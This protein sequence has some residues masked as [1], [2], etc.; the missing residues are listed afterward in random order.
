MA[1]F[2][3]R[4]C[5]GLI[6]GMW[7]LMWGV[8]LTKYLQARPLCCPCRDATIQPLLSPRGRN[9]SHHMS[10]TSTLT[11]LCLPM[12]PTGPEQHAWALARG[13]GHLC[14]QHG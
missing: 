4:Y 9:R 3:G 2:M 13:G 7:P 11:A 6:T 1:D 14:R 12:L 5:R 10:S 8:I